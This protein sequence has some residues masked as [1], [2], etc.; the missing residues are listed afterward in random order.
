[1][2]VR[3]H[4][5]GLTGAHNYTCTYAF[6][7]VFVHVQNMLFL[8]SHYTHTKSWQE[9]SSTDTPAVHEMKSFAPLFFSFRLT[10]QIFFVRKVIHCQ[11]H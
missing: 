11:S 6:V 8:G 2:Q 7:K 10:C 4:A 9:K 1:M 3:G 5:L